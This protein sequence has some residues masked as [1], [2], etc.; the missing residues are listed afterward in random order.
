MDGRKKR[1][2]LSKKA[3]ARGS[4]RAD[5]WCALFLRNQVNGSS[6]MEG[7]VQSSH[8]MNSSRETAM[9]AMPATAP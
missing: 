9:R 3:R 5:E 6:G 4:D 1:R 7:F 2:A 8:Y